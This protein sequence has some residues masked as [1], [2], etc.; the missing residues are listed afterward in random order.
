MPDFSL[1]QRSTSRALSVLAQSR[2]FWDS[3]YSPTEPPTVG[4]LR[5]TAYLC[6]N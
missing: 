3:R 6:L 1:P 2:A 5:L 4:A